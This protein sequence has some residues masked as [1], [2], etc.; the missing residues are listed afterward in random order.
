MDS[1]PIRSAVLTGAEPLARNTNLYRFDLDV[2]L[3]FE[4]GQFAN[5]TIPGATP[6]GE[7]S[8]S[9]WAPPDPAGN[10]SVEFAIQLFAGGQASDYLRSAPVGTPFELRGP[11]GHF[12]LRGDDP[13]HPTTAHW[14]LATSTGLAPF[15][16]MLA[17]A[18]RAGDPR[19]FRLLFGCR[20]EQDMFGLAALDALRD[21]LDFAYS[22]CLS[23]PQGATRHNVG[24][25]TAHMPAADPAARYYLC[26]NGAM[27]TEARELLKARGID[28]KRIHHEKYW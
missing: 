9:M 14:F 26:G 13:D 7:R 4:A 27:I 25:I 11:Y 16:A 6:R 23:R 22:V 21:R 3:Q 19:R 1:A 12:T 15:H 20:E 5:L 28:R 10:A 17:A 18:A 8:Y 24:R 2:P